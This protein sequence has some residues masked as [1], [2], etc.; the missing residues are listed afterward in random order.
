[1]KN[2]VLQNNKKKLNQLIKKMHP[3]DILDELN[4]FTED[5][6]T[7]FYEMLDEKEVAR[8]VAYLEPE[9]AASVIDN[10]ELDSQQEIIDHMDLDDAADIFVHLENQDALI[11]TEENKDIKEILTYDEDEVGAHMSDAY[12][13]LP[14][15]LDVKQATKKVIKEAGDIEDINHLYVIDENNQYA[16]VVELKTL[17]KVKEPLTVQDLIQQQPYVFVDDD[18][19]DAVHKI[20]NYGL[21]AI[22][23]LNRTFEIKGILTVDDAIEIY[24]EEALEDYEKL[25]AL[26]DTQTKGFFKSAIKRLPWL[27]ML[28]VL[29]IPIALATSSFE[30]VIASVAVLA[31]FQP[32]ILD[33]GGDVATQTLAVTLRI[34]NK[35]EKSALKNGTKELLSGALSGLLL[36]V[37]AAVVSYII[38]L[39][40]G[41]FEPFNVALIVG[42][43]LT[44]TVIA[45]PFF[46]LFIPVILNRFKIDPA[47]ASG[48]FIT[49]LID[50]TSVFIY[51]GLATFF[52]G[53]I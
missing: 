15:D 4:T 34:L 42:I 32:L 6:K 36:G 3:Y 30:E 33:A 47:V 24:H 25:A 19:E 12:I 2:L 14:I 9:D 13:T 46:A 52:L 21:Y 23:V 17:I 53:V 29:S 26:P 43:S 31:L 49:T 40:M 38:S 22:A 5:E 27:L 18:I 11:D 48:P 28:L 20:Q 45:G 8:I 7:R 37:A 10:F 16:G 50:V 44:L 51:F 35:D 39:Q 1:M 41:V